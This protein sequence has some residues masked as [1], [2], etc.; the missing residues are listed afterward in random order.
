MG[1]ISSILANEN[2][3]IRD[4]H[5]KINESLANITIVLDIS[6]IA[7]LSRVLTLIETLPNVMEAFRERPG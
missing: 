7:Q 1:D 5:V 2:I 4:L 6:D 3:N